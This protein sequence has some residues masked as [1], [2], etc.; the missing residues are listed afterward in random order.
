MLYSIL[1]QTDGQICG[2]LGWKT[3][4]A[5]LEVMVNFRLEDCYKKMISNLCK[6]QD[7]FNSEETK[8]LDECKP[9]I[10]GPG[11]I[12]IREF[13]LA[14]EQKV[15]MLGGS[16]ADGAGCFKFAKWTK[17]APYTIQF[18]QNMF[19]EYVDTEPVEYMA[20]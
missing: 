1:F 12:D 16:Y 9:S 7:T 14:S 8:W 6:I 13:N 20:I 3:D 5:N 4:P 15:W 2:G 11:D 19:N 18:A 10:V 17:W